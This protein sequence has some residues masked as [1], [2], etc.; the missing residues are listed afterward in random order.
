MSGEDAMAGK[1]DDDPFGAPVRKPP[2]RHEIGQP[3]DIL[4]VGEL[5]ERISLLREEIARLEATKAAK[6]LSKKAA[7]AFFKS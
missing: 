5:D 7:D 4:S 6:E 3:L 2:S 1:E